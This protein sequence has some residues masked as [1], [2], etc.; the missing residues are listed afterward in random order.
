V[1]EGTIPKLARAIYTDRTFTD[2]PIL[3]DC[4]E[5]S[6]CHNQEI[7]NHLRSPRPHCR[8]CWPLDLILG[9]A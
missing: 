7:L 2:L 1:Q 9:K 8:G 4:L 6:G 5:E 3:A